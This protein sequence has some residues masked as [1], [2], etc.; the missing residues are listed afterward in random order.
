MSYNFDTL[1]PRRGTNCIKWDIYPENVLPMFIADMDFPVAP[2]IMEAVVRRATEHPIYG[3]TFSDHEIFPA[4]RGWLAATYGAK[5]TDGDL[6]LLSGI[7]PALSLVSNL[8]D[9][10]SITTTPNYGHL[11]SAPGRAGNEVITV[12]L[13]NDQERY[14]L[15]FGALEQALTPDTKLFYLCS[16]H[17]PVGRIWKREELEA[18]SAFAQRHN[19]LVVS[20]EIHCELVFDRPHIPFFTV[21][22][23]ARNHSICLYAPGKTYNLAGNNLAVAVVSNQE[24]KHRLKSLSYAMSSP[25]IFQTAAASAAYTCAGEWRNALVDYLRGNRDYVEAELNRRFPLAKHPHTEGTYLQW[26]DF[27]P[28]GAEYTRDWF[29]KQADVALTDGAEFG[30]PGCVRLNFG[31]PRAQVTQALDRIEAAM[32]HAERKK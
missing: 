30:G 24:L 19:L 2:V 5:I 31:C 27:R 23:Y 10:N 22:D 21:S 7:V 14:T 3:Y 20:D 12:P 13:R 8:V 9:G 32:D 16:P 15:D 4:F 6:L 1:I 26:I 18:V 17:N 11:L 25:G 29:L 28:Y